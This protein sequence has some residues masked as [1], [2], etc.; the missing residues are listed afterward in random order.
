[1]LRANAFCFAPGLWRARAPFSESQ[2]S[3]VGREWATQTEQPLQRGLTDF[4]RRHKHSTCP[5]RR[6]WQLAKQNR[7][8]RQPRCEGTE[9]VAFHED[10]RR[11]ERVPL[12]LDLL[13]RLEASKGRPLQT[14]AFTVVVNANGGQLRSPFRMA[15]DQRITLVNPGTGKEA[16]CRVVGVV[17]TPEGE[18][19]I[20]FAFGQPDPLF[21]PM[22]DPSWI[23]PES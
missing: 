17:N 21:W 14:H 4:L 12:E 8:Y 23:R 22:S 1:M 7:I 16:D 10:R 18:Y 11:S 6:P 9:I 3:L 19:L 5:V 2:R 20:S 13:V 15:A